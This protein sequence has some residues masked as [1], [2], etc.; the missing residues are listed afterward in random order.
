M[1]KGLKYFPHKGRNREELIREQVAPHSKTPNDNWYDNYDRI[2][3]QK[4]KVTNE[5]QKR[6]SK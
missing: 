3:K 5:Y 1:Q 4:R 6:N 2:F